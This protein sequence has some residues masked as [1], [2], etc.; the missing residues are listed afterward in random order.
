[1]TEMVE[2][3]KCRATIRGG[4]KFCPECGAPVEG[5]TFGRGFVDALPICVGLELPLYAVIGFVLGSTV[6]VSYNK[7]SVGSLWDA[8]AV[9]LCIAGIVLA[10]PMLA[11]LGLRVRRLHDIG[12]S[13]W[14]LLLECIPY[15][16]WCLGLVELVLD[17]LP[18]QPV[19]NPH[20][21]PPKLVGELKRREKE[22]RQQ[23]AA[24]RRKEQAERDGAHQAAM[25]AWQG[26]LAALGEGKAAGETKTLHLPG[27]VPLPMTWCPPGVFRMGST[28]D[29]PGREEG[30]T[31]HEVALTHGFWMA[32]T[33]LTQAQWNARKE[34]P[35]SG[36]ENGNLPA[37]GMSWSEADAFCRKF[38]FALPTE[39]QWEYA[40]RAG[41]TGRYGGSGELG[42]MG[43]FADNAGDVCHPV[44]LKAPNAWGLRDM[45]GN[46]G[47][48][49]RDWFA[50]YPAG[51]VQDPL[52]PGYGSRR[53]IRGGSVKSTAER[54]RS[55]HRN[56]GAV[57]ASRPTLGFRPVKVP[58]LAEGKEG[59]P[60]GHSLP[61]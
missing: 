4:G 9:P 12:L 22:A 25:E 32:T 20:G 15:V 26:E 35:A 40:C 10:Y 23:S 37:G 50:P 11:F 56:R 55:A 42:E 31:P 3:P 38:G 2:C 17:C 49:C 34:G 16:G 8:G 57:N 5:A 39:A 21:L 19:A 7:S 1:M 58:S 18:G 28:E 29:E 13:G 30:E 45:H 24:E 54:C 36:G 61:G 41:S 27:G 48:W 52:G 47:E 60:G 53:V 44:G 59:E 14:W 43:W 33:P 46:V 51:P 6:F